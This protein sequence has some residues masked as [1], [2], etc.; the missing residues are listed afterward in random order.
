MQAVLIILISLIAMEFFSWLVHKYIMH[1]ALW[2]IHKSHHAHSKYFL[3]ANDLFSLFFATIAVVLIFTGIDKGDFRLWIGCGI[4]LYGLLYF[5]LHDVLIHKRV[6]V[7]GRPGSRYL[8][9]ISNAHKDHHKSMRKDISGSYGLFIVS[10]R[11]LRK[12][13]ILN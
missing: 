6:K 8:K 4:T 3:E 1:G 7:F 11:Y 9:A 2:F 13:K 5:I 10:A 12:G